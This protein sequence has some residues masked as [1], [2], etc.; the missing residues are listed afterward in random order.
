M[1]DFQNKIKLKN[2]HDWNLGDLCKYNITETQHDTFYTLIL[3][4]LVLDAN[5]SGFIEKFGFQNPNEIDLTEQT[6]VKT[7]PMRE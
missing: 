3:Y 5:D 2:D 4:L 6:V 7:E 1:V